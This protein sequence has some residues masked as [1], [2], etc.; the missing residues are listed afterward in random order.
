MEE[1]NVQDMQN[2]EQENLGWAA[3]RERRPWKGEFRLK[4]D[5]RSRANGVQG[6]GIE[7]QAEQ[8]CKST[9]EARN[10]LL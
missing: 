4:L 6:E 2:V 5:R 3:D 10:S 8:P 9:E 1:G 7:F